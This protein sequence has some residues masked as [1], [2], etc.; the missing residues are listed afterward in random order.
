MIHPQ[1][2]QDV[3]EFVYSPDQNW[4]NVALCHL[5]TNGSSLLKVKVLQKVL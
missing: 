5:L 1:T 2:I 4:I 3:D